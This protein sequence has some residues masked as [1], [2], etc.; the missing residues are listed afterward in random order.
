MKK[1]QNYFKNYFRK[2]LIKKSDNLVVHSDLSTF[3]I[4]DENL[5]K[6][7]L[8]T[9]LI[10]I[11]SKGNL[12]LPFYNLTSKKNYIHDNK[13]PSGYISNLSKFFFDNYAPI[14]S[15]NPIHSHIGVGPK[16]DHLKKTSY[17]KSFGEKT[18]FDFFY[19]NNFKILLLGCEP[20]LGATYIHHLEYIVKVPYRKNFIF[21]KRIKIKDEIKEINFNYYGRKIKINYN[22]NNKYYSILSKTKNSRVINNRFGKS[23]IIPAR[24]LQ[25]IGAKNLIKDKNY[26]ISK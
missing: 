2:L 15:K 23:C 8:D 3:G 6:I 9:L 14:R 4:N 18:D 7:I 11:G 22:I 10:T 24:D 1:I 16:C 5:C 12:I 25:K 26:F 19:K 20:H 13:I 17:L 21:K